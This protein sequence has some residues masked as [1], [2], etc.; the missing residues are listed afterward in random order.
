MS[1]GQ[2]TRSPSAIGMLVAALAVFFGTSGPVRAAQRIRLNLPA[3]VGTESA[4]HGARVN[5]FEISEYWVS[6]P[7]KEDE[8]A[9]KRASDLWDMA[10]EEQQHGWRS[11]VRRDPKKS[12]EAVYS[13]CQDKKES[14]DVV[15]VKE[16]D[17]GHKSMTIELEVKPTHPA[18]V[19]ELIRMKYL[20]CSRYDS[21]DKVDGWRC[22][23]DGRMKEIVTEL[24]LLDTLHKNGDK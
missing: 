18:S 24:G 4:T 3:S 22:C 11:K 8:P 19:H 23:R 17:D 14:C 21:G 20:P 5:F 10:S 12:F 13:G 15:R 6:V 2:K 7:G 16:T 9:D 1:T